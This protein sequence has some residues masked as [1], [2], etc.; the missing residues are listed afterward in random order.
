ML[1]LF[2]NY[3]LFVESLNFISFTKIM[4]TMFKI[5]RRLQ[6]YRDNQISLK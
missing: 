1:C 2:K 5:N 3:L 4:Y 6:R